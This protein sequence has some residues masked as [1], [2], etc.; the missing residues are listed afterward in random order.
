MAIKDI[1]IKQEKIKRAKNRQTK[2]AV[3]PVVKKVKKAP[4]SV[5]GKNEK[6][7]VKNTG[8]AAISL[9]APHVTE[10][11][12]FLSE[13]GVYVFKVA[14]R[15]NKIMI[16]QSIKELYGVSPEKVRIINSP[17]KNV[18]SRGHAGIKSGYKKAMIYL[19]K[20]DK[21]EL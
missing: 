7:E 10:K 2:G 4:L 18:I 21:I 11:S 14:E 1:F 20:G 19:K 16:K 8:V 6:T 17:D 12:T 5:A 9:I 15:S 13:S 3:K